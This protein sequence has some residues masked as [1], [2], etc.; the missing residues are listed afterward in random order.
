MVFFCLLA[1]WYLSYLHTVLGH[2]CLEKKELLVISKLILH[3]TRARC[4]VC[5]VVPTL[6]CMLL[7]STAAAAAAGAWQPEL[8][9]RIQ[10]SQV[11]TIND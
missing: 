1:C 5:S 7:Y 8:L 3:F 2:D 11:N 9:I 4:M 10:S 6:V